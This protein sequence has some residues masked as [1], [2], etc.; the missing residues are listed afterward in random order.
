MR[1]DQL[2]ALRAKEIADL[3][4]RKARYTSMLEMECRNRYQLAIV[5]ALRNG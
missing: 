3:V 4:I 5:E 2:K 1:D